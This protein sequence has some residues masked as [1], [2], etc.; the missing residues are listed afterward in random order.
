MAFNNV[1]SY[2]KFYQN[3]VQITQNVTK[4]DYKYL[5]PTV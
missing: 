5:A 2:Y 4:R 1:L 3:K